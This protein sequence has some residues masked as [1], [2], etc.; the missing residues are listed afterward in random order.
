MNKECNIVR[1]LIP[2]YVED[3]ASQESADFV[4]THCNS[5]DECRKQLEYALNPIK[6]E[7]EQADIN[8]I[9]VFENLD[10][11]HKKHLR[12]KICIISVCLISVLAVSTYLFSFVFHGN[13]WFTQLE[14]S[15]DYNFDDEEYPKI[16]SIVRLKESDV[17][18]C[19]DEIES[20]FRKHF[21]G[22]VLLEL[23]FDEEYSTVDE[24]RFQ[25]DF[26]VLH[27]SPSLRA[28]EMHTY[29]WYLKYNKLTDKWIVSSY[30][31]Y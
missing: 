26:Y 29:D 22:C 25:S 14:Y 23:R 24:I 4:T 21:D 3:L 19:A 11:I 9:K 1:D 16:Y 30:G 10:K 12:K 28:G 5:C 18:K 20:Y 31:I 2:V 17:K 15:E 6:S 7:E 13:T 27:S 8:M